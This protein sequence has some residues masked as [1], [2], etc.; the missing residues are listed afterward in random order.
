MSASEAPAE[1]S[2]ST[3]RTARLGL[4]AIAGL[5]G[6][7]VVGLADA[8][9]EHDGPSRMDPVLSAGVVSHRAPTLTHVAE[10]FTFAGGELVVGVL[11]VTVCVWLVLRG[12]LVRAATFALGIGGS[13]VLT[14]LVKLVVARARP[15]A[16]I[17]LG[18]PDTS[19][20]FP[21]GTPSTPPSSSPSSS[22]WSG[23]GWLGSVG[24]WR[25][26]APP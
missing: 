6:A 2:R 26:R 18:P 20:S 22:G 3:P 7:G 11:A 9:G 4:L 14:V 19:Y 25:C 21:S 8:A 5:S 12:D 24:P 10:A 16:A 1:A 15:G 13:A 17:R 23:R